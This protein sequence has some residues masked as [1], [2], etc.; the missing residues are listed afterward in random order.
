MDPPTI[1]A[2]PPPFDELRRRDDNYQ[3]LRGQPEDTSDPLTSEETRKVENSHIAA[4]N[5]LPRF[6]DQVN[7]GSLHLDSIPAP[8]SRSHPHPHIEQHKQ[9]PPSNVSPSLDDNY[10]IANEIPPDELDIMIAAPY[11]DVR[12]L[13]HSILLTNPEALAIAVNNTSADLVPAAFP[14]HK[15]VLA[16]GFAE[17]Q[18]PAQATRRPAFVTVTV[19]KPYINAKL[20]ITMAVDGASGYVYISAFTGKS[21]L[22]RVIAFSPLGVGDKI[23]TV[24]GKSC[25]GRTTQSVVDLICKAPGLITIAIENVSGDPSLVETMVEK[26]NPHSKVGLGFSYTTVDGGF[27]KVSSVSGMFANSFVEVG[28]R[29]VFVNG[30]KP[31]NAAE[32]TDLIARSPRFVSLT[33][34]SRTGVVIP[35]ND[36]GIT[37]M[38]AVKDPTPMTATTCNC[39]IL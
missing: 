10:G 5:I 35:V 15:S 19:T 1:A 20:G 24:N 2:I 37:G 16:T 39:C 26:D 21:D 7:D 4:P 34:E 18:F 6:K 30:K 13:T 3:D 31:R 8:Y 22:S 11:A 29:V 38:L 28:D 32:A 25:A 36:E 23:L 27:L 12:L 33:V 9:S 14:I 17:D